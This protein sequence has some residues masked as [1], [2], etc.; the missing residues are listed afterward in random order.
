VA[1]IAVLSALNGL[2]VWA[3]YVLLTQHHWVSAPLVGAALLAIDWVYMSGNRVLPA[4][5]LIPGTIFLVG[6]MIIPILYDVNV[7]FTHY[8]TGH[9]GTKAA[10]IQQIDLTS[11]QPPAN[12]KSYTMAAAHDAGGKLVLILQDDAT[13]KDFVGTQQG[14][15]PLPAG[16]V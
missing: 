14:L 5:F 16:S 15:T 6:F 11:L 13:H 7:A 9:I 12:G 8:G 10:A 3:I 2:A 1:K 4:K